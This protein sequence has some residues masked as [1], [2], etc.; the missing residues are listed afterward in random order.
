MLVVLLVVAGCERGGAPEATPED[1]P[2][3]PGMAAGHSAHSA[4]SGT[5]A[6]SHGAAAIMGLSVAPVRIGVG[7]VERRA[8]ASVTLDPTGI[9]RV[10]TQSGGQVRSLSVPAPGGVV[11]KGQI[12]A[13]LYDPSLRALLEELRVARTLDGS[14]SSAA[15]SRARA[16]GVPEEEV[17]AVLDGGAVGETIAIRAPAGGV[18]SARPVAE[19]AWVPAG[20]LLATLV[21][22]DAVLVD[23]VVDGAPPAAGTSVTLRDPGGTAVGAATVERVLP[24]ATAAGVRVRVGPRAPVTPGRPLIAEW[25]E[26]TATALWIPASALVDTGTRR[27]VFVRTDAGFVPR[28]VEVGVRTRDE[29]EV[30]SGV[31][32]GEKVA[33]SAAFLL[34]SETQI[35]SMAHQGHGG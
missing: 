34:D 26:E 29:I 35:G 21:D 17:R 7:Q 13:R 18:V 32:A 20:G 23:L 15:A 27:V 31:A 30:L 16:S 8:P 12:L 10:T 33:A 25:M 5:I 11:T 24:E 9:A 1:M 22:P 28:P 14:W 3:M 4:P 2:G 6:P 19:G